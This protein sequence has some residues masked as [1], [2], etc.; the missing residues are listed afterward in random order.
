MI[1]GAVLLAAVTLDAFAKRARVGRPVTRRRAALGVAWLARLRLHGE[2]ALARVA[3]LPALDPPL[4][5]AS[6]SRSRAGTATRVE[7][8]RARYGWAEAVTDWREQ[9][10][11][12]RVGLFDNGGPNAMHA[13]PTIAAARAGKH[14]LCEKP[15][16]R[17]ANE[18]HEM[19]PAAEEAGVVHMCGFNYR[20]VPAVRRAR[21]LLEAG[22]LGEL[23]HFRARYLQSWGER[24][25]AEL[26]LRAGGGRLGRDRRPRRAHRRPGA[27]PRRR[28]ESR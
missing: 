11:D 4:V 20:F 21:E 7:A 16:G 26:A 10:A 22:E 25:R 17:D 19:W 1:T 15:L 28:A 27:L 23:F 3:E 18:A 13:E 24:R 14:V 2:G 12:E 6:S 5:A 8:A 9:V